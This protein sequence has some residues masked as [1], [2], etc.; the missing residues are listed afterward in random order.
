[1]SY[2]Q[3]FV[4]THRVPTLLPLY[5]PSFLDFLPS[6]LWILLLDVLERFSGSETGLVRCVWSY[7]VMDRPGIRV[8]SN[9][10]RRLLLNLVTEKEPGIK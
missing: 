9:G 6:L 1:M 5:D 3:F 4:G 8:G 2:D 7:S 10:L